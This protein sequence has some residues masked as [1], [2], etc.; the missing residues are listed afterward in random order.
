MNFYHYI[1]DTVVSKLTTIQ[2][3]QSRVWFLPGRDNKSL[4]SKKCPDQ[5]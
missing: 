1:Q 3:G 2:A 5:V 4:S